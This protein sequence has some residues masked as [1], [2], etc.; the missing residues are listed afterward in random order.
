MLIFSTFRLLGIRR[1]LE[2]RERFS[3]LLLNSLPRL[4]SPFKV[5]LMRF[6]CWQHGVGR[7]VVL[8]EGAVE[9]HLRGGPGEAERGPRLQGGRR[10]RL[11]P[12]RRRRQTPHTQ[13][14][15]RR[16]YQRRSPPTHVPFTNPCRPIITKTLHSE[17]AWKPLLDIT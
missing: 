10:L 16:E 8:A 12:R 6:I 15:R 4:V 2:E 7:P 17:I 9:R 1:H 13:N 3:K 11:I 5:S 14:R